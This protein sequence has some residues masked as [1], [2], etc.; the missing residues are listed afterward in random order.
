MLLIMGL[1]FLQNVVIKGKNEQGKIILQ[2]KYENGRVIIDIADD[3]SGLD[4]ERVK[5][6]L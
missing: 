4:I 2:A 6:K 5:K 1:N 3:G